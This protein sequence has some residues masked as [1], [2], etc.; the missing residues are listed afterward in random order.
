MLIYEVMRIRFV[1]YMCV[2]FLG[3]LSCENKDEFWRERLM[4]T[5]S[6]V[7]Y[8]TVM[9]WTD[10]GYDVLGGTMT[11]ETFEDRTVAVTGTFETTGKAIGLNLK[12][13]PARVTKEDGTDLVY[14]FGL[15]E[16]SHYL[17]MIEGEYT[18]EGVAPDRNGRLMEYKAK[19][20]IDARKMT[21]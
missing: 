7:D 14:T 20:K 11:I 9:D 15:M 18:V 1:L 3:C 6:F 13:E 10:T 12:L 17:Y 21:R 4:G 2:L 8:R 5:Y 16:G 19:G